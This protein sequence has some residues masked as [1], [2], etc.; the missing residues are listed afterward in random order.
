[1]SVYQVPRNPKLYIGENLFIYLVEI[2]GCVEITREYLGFIL[3]YYLMIFF[4]DVHIFL[5][6]GYDVF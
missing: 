3:V 2:E 5:S 1:M 4:F 6:E